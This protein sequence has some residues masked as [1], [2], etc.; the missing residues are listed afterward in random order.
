MVV[1]MN[2]NVKKILIIILISSIIIS[3]LYIVKV[4]YDVYGSKKQSSL[5]NEISLKQEAIDKDSIVENN[6][7]DEEP[8]SLKTERML[9]LEELQKENPEIVAY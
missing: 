9:K 5:L 3:L 7:T 1:F 6:I 2:K 8:K 4:A